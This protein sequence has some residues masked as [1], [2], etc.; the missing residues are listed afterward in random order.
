[1]RAGSE[2]E[3]DGESD[4][5]SEGGV[6]GAT[7]EVVPSPLREQIQAKA[8]KV[9]YRRRYGRRRLQSA[10]VV[11]TSAHVLLRACVASL[12]RSAFGCSV[13]ACSGGPASRVRRRPRLALAWRRRPLLPALSL[14]SCSKHKSRGGSS[15]RSLSD[16]T[17]RNCL[18]PL[19]SAALACI[20]PLRSLSTPP[21]VTAP[22]PAFGPAV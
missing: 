16:A 21:A 20:S 2:S 11:A 4:G 10:T 7:A 14:A 9:R 5:G 19:P 8:A 22:D 1:M 12:R 6:G 17:A 18:L 13:G 3:S 15:L